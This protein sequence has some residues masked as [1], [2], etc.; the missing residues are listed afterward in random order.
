MINRNFTP[1]IVLTGLF[2]FLGLA[3]LFSSRGGFGVVR[4]EAQR[5]GTAIY[6]QNCARCHGSDGRAQTPK[7]RETDAVDLTSDDWSPDTAR[8]TRIV[9]NG[10]KSMPAFGRRLTPA[11]LGA[12]VQYIRRFKR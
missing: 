12:V 3:V 7:G 6:A 2:L 9:N 11:Q 10:K 1:K 4:V 8:D 5:G